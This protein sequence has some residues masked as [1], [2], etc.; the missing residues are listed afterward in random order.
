M[1]RRWGTLAVVERP[2]GSKAMSRKLL[3]G[4]FSASPVGRWRTTSTSPRRAKGRQF[5]SRRRALL[6]SQICTVIIFGFSIKQSN[7][8]P[9]R[10]TV[11]S[12]ALKDL[13]ACSLQQ[14]TADDTEDGMA[15]VVLLPTQLLQRH[16]ISSVMLFDYS[17]QRSSRDEL[18]ALFFAPSNECGPCTALTLSTWPSVQQLRP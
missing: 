9:S 18:M 3:L 14:S 10:V 8:T 11:T 1:G 12:L 5:D 17:A 2:R 7:S 15:L 13:T 4:G 6:I 16:S